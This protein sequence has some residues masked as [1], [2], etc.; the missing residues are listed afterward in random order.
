MYQGLLWYK[1]NYRSA[2]T[3]RRNK[4]KTRLLPLHLKNMENSSFGLKNVTGNSTDKNT[5]EDEGFKIFLACILSVTFVVGLIGNG[6]VIFLTGCRMKMTVNSTW[7]LNLAIADFIFILI[8]ITNFSLK[9]SKQHSDFTEYFFI[10]TTSLNLFISV[11]S[12]VVISLDRCLCTWMPVWAQNNRTLRKAR[13][14][15]II[16]WVSSIGYI[17][18]YFKVFNITDTIIVTYEF[19]VVFFIT[20]LIITSSYIAIGVKINRLKMG[21]QLRSYRLI[22][23]VIL[24]FFICSFPHHVC[25]ILRI[26]AN[27]NNWTLTKQ[28]WML[29]DFTF[30]LINLNSSLNPFLYVFMSKDY[31]KKLKQ[32]LVLVLETAFTEGHLDVKEM[33]QTHHT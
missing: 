11:W 1:T 26:R 15:C 6:L 13:I 30:Y 16:I 12:L 27:N 20:F 9:W 4:I 33:R 28:F 14:I 18:P 5:V 17:L 31:K 25:W 2:Q 19:I 10:I 32:S 3:R 29:F 24:T 7:F 22:I 23:T 21:K 8:S